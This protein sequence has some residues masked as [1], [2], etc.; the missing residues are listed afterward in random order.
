MYTTVSQK[1][2]FTPFDE[3][4]NWEFIFE[5]FENK[6]AKAVVWYYDQIAFYELNDGRFDYG[7]RTVDELVRLRIF[8]KDRELHIWRS[9]GVLKGRLR[10]D[11]EGKEM[12][13][14][15]A[16]Q[17]MNGTHFITDGDFLH[18]TEERGTDYK[19]P[20][21]ELLKKDKEI[22]RLKLI[23]R[24][25]VGYNEIGQAGYVDSR[26]ESIEILKKQLYGDR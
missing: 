10:T 13:Y 6:D 4:D 22:E 25:Y 21:T 7:T 12:K 16:G 2:N 3:I 8:N 1:T 15:L 20:F 19:L 11:G 9:N 18:V 17:I 24:N 26:F 5:S 14:V 23:T